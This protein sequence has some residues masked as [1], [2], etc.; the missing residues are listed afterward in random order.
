MTDFALQSIGDHLQKL[1]LPVR[2][3]NPAW[4][5]QFK[6]PGWFK[7]DIVKIKKQEQCGVLLSSGTQPSGGKVMEMA[8]A[9][10]VRCAGTGRYRVAR[11]WYQGEQV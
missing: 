2:Y 10:C 11:R 1:G 8:A 3:C 4:A 7:T 9:S 6:T 5:K